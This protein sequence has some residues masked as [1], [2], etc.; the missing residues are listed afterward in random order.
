MAAPP[1]GGAPNG[2]GM[3]PAGPQQMAGLN[4]G[5]GFAGLGVNGG[6]YG[7]GFDPSGGVD[8]E[9]MNAMF[10]ARQQQL[11]GGGNFLLPRS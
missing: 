1:N 9:K 4:G 5:G 3:L 11:L 2:L 10:L 6:G 7:G 8:V